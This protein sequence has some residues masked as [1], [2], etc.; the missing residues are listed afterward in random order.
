MII[1][2]DTDRFITEVVEGN[3]YKFLFENLVVLDVGCNI[4]M[5]SLWIRK[6]ATKIYAVDIS[7]ENIDN[8]NKTIEENK[9][10][11]IETFLCGIAGLSGKRGIDNRG[12]AGMGGW[13]LS[14]GSGDLDVYSVNDFMARQEIDYLDVL[15]L[16]VEGAEDEILLAPDFPKDKIKTI[17]G[18]CHGDRM[19]NI[20]IGLERMNYRFHNLGGHFLA[21]KI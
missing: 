13:A 7:K 19:G 4:G 9:L 16:D 17:I 10:E 20:H 6:F 15:K 8:F 18:E 12:S 1:H 5:F 3:E 14:S 2:A 21:R 11:N